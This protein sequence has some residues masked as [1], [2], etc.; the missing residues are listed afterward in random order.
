MN[1]RGIRELDVVECLPLGIERVVVQVQPLEVRKSGQILKSLISHIAVAECEKSEPLQ[2]FQVYERAVSQNCFVTG[3]AP[4]EKLLRV[5][6]N[7]DRAL[8]IP[9]SKSSSEPYWPKRLGLHN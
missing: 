2:R 9:I 5:Y 6:V 7:L 3:R 1:Q 4:K 8:D